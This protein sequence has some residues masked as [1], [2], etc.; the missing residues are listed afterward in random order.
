MRDD[1][2]T[3][4]A[5][6]GLLNYIVEERIARPQ[7]LDSLYKGLPESAREAIARR[8][9]LGHRDVSIGDPWWATNWATKAPLASPL[10][11]WFEGFRP[12]SPL[13]QA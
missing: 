3:V 7:K 4:G 6:F 13:T 11:A 1:A 5:L 9:P 10:P 8:T 2:E 12:D